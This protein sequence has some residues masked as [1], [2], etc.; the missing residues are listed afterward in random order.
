[1]L[2]HDERIETAGSGNFLP[3]PFKILFLI[4]ALALF[5]CASANA[6]AAVPDAAARIQAAYRQIRDASGRFEQKSYL[7]DLGKTETFGGDFMLKLPSK[8]RYIYKTGS[9]DQVIIKG[10]MIMIYQKKENQIMK[11][12]FDAGTY[13]TAPVAF[14]GGLGDIERDFRV[15]EKK[16]D[17][18]LRPKD[19]MSGITYIEVEP[20]KGPSSFPVKSFIIHDRYSNTVR[21]TLRDVKLNRGMKDSAFEFTPPPGTSVFDYTH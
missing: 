7:K 3:R 11:G 4:S 9:N 2:R 10:N 21:I 12:R 16:G 8:M 17:L 18:I 5:L 14:L 20:T 15:T 13:G 1:M 6:G 19:P